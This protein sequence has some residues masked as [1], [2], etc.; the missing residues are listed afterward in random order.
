MRAEG[1][2]L[3]SQMLSADK[4]ILAPLLVPVSDL[5]DECSPS[6][7]LD[8]ARL[9]V[10]ALV[11]HALM[12]ARINVDMDVFTDGKLLDRSADGREPALTFL[13]AQLLPRVLPLTV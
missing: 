6:L 2:A 9:A 4:Q 10:E 3:K 5:H 7:T 11:R 12:D 1:L 13:L 8:R